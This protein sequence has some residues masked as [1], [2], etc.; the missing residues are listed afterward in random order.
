MTPTYRRG[1]IPDNR[2]HSDPT[3]RRWVPD[4]VAANAMPD[5]VPE[6]DPERRLRGLVAVF[7]NP[8]VYDFWHSHPFHGEDIN[9]DD[10]DGDA[11]FRARVVRDVREY[12][13][14]ME[15][16]IEAA[17]AEARRLLEVLL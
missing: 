16:D 4:T 11:E 3:Q 5:P 9:D 15:L 14:E 13:A 2:H 6:P 8:L 10:D 17:E 7:V 12:A 1:P